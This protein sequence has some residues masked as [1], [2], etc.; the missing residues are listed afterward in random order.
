MENILES[1]FSK[2]GDFL[3]NLQPYLQTYWTNGKINFEMLLEERLR[4]PTE[5]LIYSSK[6]FK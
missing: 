3:Q 4:Q 5:M 2:A 6:L 1:A